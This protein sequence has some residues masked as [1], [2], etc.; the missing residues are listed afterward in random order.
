MIIVLGHKA[1]AGK[2]EAAN[3]LVRQHGF[4]KLAFATSLKES[5]RITHGYNDEQL[6][7][8]LKEVVDPFWG[9]TPRESMVKVGTNALRKHYRDDIWIMSSIRK[10]HE[11]QSAEKDIVVSDGR[12]INEMLSIKYVGGFVVR[13]D[14]SY[15]GQQK[16]T[17]AKHISEVELEKYND[18]DWIIKNDSTL[19]AYYDK[20]EDMYQFFKHDY[21]DLG[22]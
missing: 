1:R 15:E 12:F 22:K 18:W 3:Y 2:D 19:K 17:V 9:E 13:I 21:N 8:D 7:G 4:V 11:L 6:Y 14:A 10:I 5:L 20:V 16:T